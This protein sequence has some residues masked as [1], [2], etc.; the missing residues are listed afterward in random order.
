[1]VIEYRQ[2]CYSKSFLQWLKQDL[3]GSRL[4]YRPRLSVMESDLG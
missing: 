2:L 4:V 3:N 1:M